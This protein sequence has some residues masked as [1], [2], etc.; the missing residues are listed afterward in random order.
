MTTRFDVSDVPLQGGYVAKQ[1]PVRAQ[2]DIL[3]PGVPTPTSAW[4]QRLFDGGIA[5]EAEIVTS[6]VE[7]CPD[8]VVISDHGDDAE[9]ATL[10]AMQS[11]APVILGGRLP[12]DEV[13]R[14]VGKPDLLVRADE[15]GGGYRA[16]DVKHHMAVDA[17]PAGR[18]GFPGRRSSLDRLALEQAVDDSETSGRK[19]QGDLLQLA[20]YQRMLEAAGMATDDGRWA[21][22][23]GTERKVVWYDLDLPAW[24]T[25][26]V[27]ENSK[28]RST[29]ER[30]DFEFDFRLDVIA[31]AQQ[32]QRD[33]SV[34]LA[35]VPVKV[36][37][38]AD[39]PWWDYC[40]PRLEAGSGDVSLLPRIGWAQWKV[41]RDH[42]VTNRAELAALDE[43]T[44]GYSG[45][46]LRALPLHIDLARAA[47]GPEPAYRK[48]GVDAVVAPRADVEV[49]VDME[50]VEE[51]CY[52]WGVLVTDRGSA[53]PV[54]SRYEAFVTWDPMT[55][56]V[57]TDN[58][59]RFWR[60][61]MELRSTTLAARRS[62]RAYCYSEQAE[63]RFLKRLG[64]AAAIADEVNAFIDSDEWVDMLQVWDDQLITG[65]SS[66]LKVAAPI[67]GFRWE[68]DDAGGGESMLR[69]EA[70][71][72]DTEDSA[73]ARE[74]L[75]AYNRGD[76][77]ATLA[78]REWMH[79]TD[80]PSIESVQPGS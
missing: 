47:L 48:R 77:E 41:H 37:E 9:V 16:V 80:I 10:R 1:C 46:G 73:T 58:S 68:V 18:Q 27:T 54:V 69:Y 40:R 12:S 65:G 38:C 44:A 75:L 7:V 56:D 39:C 57:E 53:D 19:K 64:L 79:S 50:N 6:I 25:P 60:S 30:Y 32:H 61:F 72:G 21:G 49:D 51:G 36:S 43:R 59:L 11:G 33:A 71:V 14:R 28:L 15:G 23:I 13:A 63:N 45:S 8:A 20:H 3:V 55:P 62:F 26:S 35:V 24:R 34:D 31:V 4:L 42:G 5:F 76:V 52:L 29:M 66:S 17:K 78:L 74:W 2:N 22:I 67:T 70:A